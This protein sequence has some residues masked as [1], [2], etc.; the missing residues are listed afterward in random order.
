MTLFQ[1]LE[2]RKQQ[3]QNVG[4]LIITNHVLFFFINLI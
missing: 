4:A 1:G 3:Q 2:Y